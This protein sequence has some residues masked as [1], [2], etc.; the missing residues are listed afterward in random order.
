MVDMNLNHKTSIRRCTESI[1][2]TLLS[3]YGRCPAVEARH[4][5]SRIALWATGVAF[6]EI[7]P[8]LERA[9]ETG[10]V[11]ALQEVAGD[12]IKKS[13][14]FLE[15]EESEEV[16]CPIAIGEWYD[17]HADELYEQA[18]PYLYEPECE[19]A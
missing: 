5:A 19:P 12:D 2:Y 17:I 1:V 16:Y 9:G 8:A 14:A 6:S 18:K 10:A 11:L 3:E 7:I 13:R 15:S 4:L